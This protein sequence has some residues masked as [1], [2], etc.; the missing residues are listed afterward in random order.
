MKSYLK[1]SVL[2]LVVSMFLLTGC[3]KDN[4]TINK[5]TVVTEYLKTNN[6]D[7]PAILSA[8]SGW[9]ITASA[10]NSTLADYYIIDLRSATDFA[11]GRIQGAVNSTLANVI[12]TANAAPAG[13]K[14]MLVCYTGQTATFALAALKLSGKTNVFFLKW[15]MCAWNSSLDVNR[16]TANI[17]NLTNSNIVT[18]PSFTTNVEFTKLPM[19]TSSLSDAQLILNERIAAVLAEGPKSVTASNVLANPSNY[20]INNFWTAQNVTD[21]GNKNIVG[22]YRI[23]P[24][25]LTNNEFKFLNPDKQIVTYCWTGQTSGAI[26]FYLRVL[27][28]DAYSLQWGANAMWNSQLASNRWPEGQQNFPLV[29]Q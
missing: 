7:L 1:F 23:N 5:Y 14:I 16:W 20:F 18:P 26:T 3:K 12:T 2:S 10:L 8:T 19:L 11:A 24:L 9:V 29:T 28:Y 25:T 4:E 22:A 27:G 21:N 6:L 15:G 13:K 17:G